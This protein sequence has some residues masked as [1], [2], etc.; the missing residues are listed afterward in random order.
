MNHV[1][2]V[3]LFRLVEGT[4]EAAFLKDAQ[5]TFDLLAS[6]DGYLDRELSVN[7]DGLWV[8]VVTWADIDT[9]L[10]ATE[11]IMDSPVGQAFGAHID[12]GSIQMQHVHPRIT[13][14]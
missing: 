4:D 3:V 12:P 1:L 10:S 6:Y 2:E 8:D 14:H 11:K 7:D 13:M 5:A 9:A